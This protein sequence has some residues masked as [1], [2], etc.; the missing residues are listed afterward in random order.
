[1]TQSIVNWPVLPADRQSRLL[2]ALPLFLQAA[3]D[4]LE[5]EL[6]PWQFSVPL[7]ELREIG[8]LGIDVRWL[9]A[10]GIVNHAAEIEGQDVGRRLHK[11]MANLA[12]T[13]A[14]CFLITEVGRRW[15]EHLSSVQTTPARPENSVGESSPPPLPFWD[16]ARRELRWNGHLVK[17]Y[18]VPAP[19]QELILSV[20]AEE[21]WSPMI[22]DPLPREHGI[23][24]EQRLQAAVRGL[25]R[26]QLTRAIRFF[27]NGTGKG[28]RWEAWNKQDGT[29]QDRIDRSTLE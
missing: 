8:L 7:R 2:L 11:R 5:C 9:I 26:N 4:A 29:R 13:D 28:I 22:D 21:G 19:S 1:M 6:D 20:F 25:N 3:V 27:R 18:R 10:Q 23:L 14:S 12:I 15:A 16:A 17:V 24:P